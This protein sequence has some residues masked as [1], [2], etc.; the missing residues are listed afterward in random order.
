MSVRIV[1]RLP[2]RVRRDCLPPPPGDAAAP[3]VPRTPLPPAPLSDEAIADCERRLA[4][5]YQLQHPAA[6]VPARP[7]ALRQSTGARV[8]LSPLAAD[9]APVPLRGES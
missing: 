6:T 8:A 9:A 7:R 2:G 1:N 3:S 4:R 5:A